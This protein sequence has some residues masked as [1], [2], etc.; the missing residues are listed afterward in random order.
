MA[1]TDDSGLKK[2]NVPVRKSSF[3]S[4]APGEASGAKVRF[5]ETGQSR[6]WKKMGILIGVGGLTAFLLVGKK[7]PPILTSRGRR[8][9]IPQSE[10]QIQQKGLPGLQPGTPNYRCDPAT[11]QLPNCYCPSTSPPGN[12]T[13]E[14]TP[15]FVLLTYDDAV[16]TITFPLS[17]ATTVSTNPNGCR[18][19]ATYFV[20]TMYTDYHLVQILEADGNEI[21][22]HTMTHPGNPDITEIEGCRKAIGAYSGVN[23]SRI[24]GFRA[25][26]LAFDMG[27][28]QALTDLGLE[29]DCTN[30]T[31][32]RYG[33]WPFTM[34]NG[35]PYMCET[36]T[37]DYDKRFPG[38]WQVPMFALVDPDTG[39]QYTVMDP[40]GTPE[41]LIGLFKFNFLLHWEKYK[42]PMGLW[43]HPA[44]FL[45]DPLNDRVQ[46]LNDFFDWTRQVTGNRVWYVTVSQLV[47]WMKDPKSVDEMLTASVVDCPAQ[48]AVAGVIG[49]EVCN[50]RDDNG[51]GRVD[52]GL[53]RRC[54]LGA[55]SSQCCFA[56]PSTN[57]I[58]ANPV[59]SP[60][61]IPE[62]PGGSADCP[63]DAVLPEGGCFQG[64]WGN[65]ACRCLNEEDFSKNGYCKDDKGVCSI[66]KTFDPVRRVFL[67]RGQ[68]PS[69]P[70]TRT[71]TESGTAT[72]TSTPTP[73][74][75]G[76][77]NNAVP[78]PGGCVQGTWAD[79]ACQCLS[80]NDRTKNGYCKDGT[81]VCTV[82][83]TY[84][85]VNRVFLCPGTFSF[86]EISR[87]D[88]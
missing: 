10:G 15:Q 80:E 42:T 18:I 27:S 16:N 11:C 61:P 52:E 12:L 70:S 60:L 14:Q 66:V 58:P 65:C 44:W 26:Y 5:E 79:C 50:G 46:L 8:A 21:A 45:N 69:A 49:K 29:Y 35:F 82:V 83:K 33:P 2:R 40:P 9:V 86:S 6:G 64:T 34:D 88:G 75:N 72:S 24:R 48:R 56:C 54:E 38:L 47:D 53:T 68:D 4:K 39:N 23:A 78:P 87:Y 3:S 36:G 1:S 62:A 67:C 51:N 77:P 73:I 81:G 30:P 55:Y 85:F 41:F 13:L 84:D 57:P 59:P 63:N 17:N 74:S 19:A 28:W 25:P 43:L 71:Q 20:S 32:P 22:I 7:D 31:D 37:C 76:C